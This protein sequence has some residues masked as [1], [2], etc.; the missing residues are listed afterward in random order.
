MA[1][2]WHK[3]LDEVSHLDLDDPSISRL[4]HCCEQRLKLLLTDCGASIHRSQDLLN[5]FE[6]LLLVKGSVT[7]RIILSPDILDNILDLLKSL[8]LFLIMYRV[9]LWAQ[10]SLIRILH[11]HG[12]LNREICLVLVLVAVS[13]VDVTPLAAPEVTAGT[14]PDGGSDHDDAVLQIGVCWV[15]SCIRALVPIAPQQ[16]GRVVAFA[17]L[18]LRNWFQSGFEGVSSHHSLLDIFQFLAFLE[19]YGFWVDFDM[20]ETV[21]AE[22]VLAEVDPAGQ[23]G[24]GVSGRH[25]SHWVV[26]ILGDVLLNVRWVVLLQPVHACWHQLAALSDARNLRAQVVALLLEV[27]RVR[28]YFSLK[29]TSESNLEC[30]GGSKVTWL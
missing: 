5:Q 2:S 8:I 12:W 16:P 27:V 26:T 11:D 13:N 6:G 9:R 23:L 30:A 25:W 1:L 29:V 24:H 19:L 14:R 7:V 10:W 21:A 20:A 3:L 4:V 22:D 28:H 15:R 18:V 17:S